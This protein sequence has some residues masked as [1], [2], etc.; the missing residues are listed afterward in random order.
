MPRATPWRVPLSLAMLRVTLTLAMLRVTLPPPPSPTPKCNPSPSQAR[1]ERR[2]H[3][4]RA[5]AAERW[6]RS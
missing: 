3:A 6:S 5:A 4:L 2:H 1:A